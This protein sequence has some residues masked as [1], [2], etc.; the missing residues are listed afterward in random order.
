M[1][2]MYWAALYTPI[3]LAEESGSQYD[4]QGGADPVGFLRMALDFG[5][6]VAMRERVLPNVRTTELLS[7]LYVH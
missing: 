1:N 4:A 2:S 7:N 5:G 3:G 6:L